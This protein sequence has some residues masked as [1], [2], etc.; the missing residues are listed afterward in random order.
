MDGNMDNSLGEWEERTFSDI[1]EINNYP[2]LEKGEKQTYVAMEQLRPS[3]REIQGTEQ[4]EYKYSAPRFE[5]GDTLFPKMSRCLEIGKTAYVNN[6]EE[7]E[8]AFG[9]TEFMVMRPKG[10]EVLPKFVYYTVR[11]EDIRQ[12]ALSWATGSTARRQRIST[13][14]FDELTIKIPPIEEQKEIVEL[15]DAID[16]KIQKNKEINE[17]L[18]KTAR[19]L[20]KGWFKEFSPYTSFQDTDLGEIPKG[21]SVGTLGDIMQKKSKK[22][23]PEQM[24]PST[25]YF[26]LK[27]MPEQSLSLERWDNT[28]DVSSRKSEF[29]K[30]DILFGKLR[31]YFCKV[32]IAPVDGVCSTDIFVI[33]P[34]EESEWRE[35]L[36]CQLSDQSFIDYCDN[37]S[38]GTRMPRVGWEEMCEY[39]IPLPKSDVVKE[40]SEITRPFFQKIVNNIHESIKLHELRD[41]IL[42]KL[43]SGEIRFSADT[44]KTV[45]SEIQ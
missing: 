11:R 38:T 41:T 34:K 18:E 43:L 29:K 32:G 45:P 6:L 14:F 1:I 35:F 44:C 19:T 2:S 15:L 16:T 10:E 8:V 12:H 25:P 9:S 26:S 36:L 21:W 23:D 13:D 3:T 37:V 17:K 33:T 28:E 40:F 4:K 42:P 5:N 31:P 22:I 24:S 30:G 7:D 39:E 27:H 20:Y